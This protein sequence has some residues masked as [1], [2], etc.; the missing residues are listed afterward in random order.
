M[1]TVF[2]GIIA[3]SLFTAVFG[4]EVLGD[5]VAVGALVLLVLGIVALAIFLPHHRGH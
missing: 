5:L 2:L 1:I 4:E 3:L